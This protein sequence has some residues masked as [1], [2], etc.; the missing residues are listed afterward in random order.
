MA[1]MGMAHHLSFEVTLVSIADLNCFSRVKCYLFGLRMLGFREVGQPVRQ[2]VCYYYRH[3]ACIIGIMRRLQTPV[4]LTCWMEEVQLTVSR[5]CLGQWLSDLD[6][7]GLFLSTRQTW[8][9]GISAEELP[10]SDKPVD[11]SVGAFP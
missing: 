1:L 10:P 8:E 6:C 5:R 7:A 9:E 3:P 2:S 11:K 4:C